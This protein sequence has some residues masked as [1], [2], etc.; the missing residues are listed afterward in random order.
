MR[1]LRSLAP[2]VAVLAALTLSSCG[3]S[4]DK[5]DAKAEPTPT[6]TAEEKHT[7]E[8]TYD[9]PLEGPGE[10]YV[11]T[12][13][14]AEGKTAQALAEEILK[15]GEVDG[16]AEGFADAFKLP[17]DLKI[18]VSNEDGSPYY[19]PTTKTVTIFYDFANLT[20]NI[21]K[22]SQTGSDGS[23]IDDTELGKQWAAV[24]DF[25]LIHEIAHAFVD[26][27]EIPVTGREEDSADG[28]ATWFFTDFV[29]NGAEYAFAAAQ[30][31]SALQDYQGSPDA[32][33][34]ADEH[35]LSI[36]RAVD[37]AC[38]VAG[39]SDENMQIMNQ[40]GF[41]PAA[42]LQRCPGEYEQMHNAWTKLL[43]PHRRDADEG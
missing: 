29:D 27:L 2:A 15:A 18:H 9:E 8:V 36:Q 21:I 38:K 6:R 24:N 28:M 35:S 37:I 34:F 5:A 43:E 23:S 12:L 40:I 13:A 22:L 25:I 10:A 3:S 19:D 11:A 17:E 32:T 33:Q 1:S 41:V 4:D 7:I 20:A 39:A 31:F 26:V 14:A 30:F 42:R 16:I